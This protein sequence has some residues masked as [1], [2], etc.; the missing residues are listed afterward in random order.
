MY[1]ENSSVK[2]TEECRRGRKK[3]KK[4]RTNIVGHRNSESY[5]IDLYVDTVRHNNK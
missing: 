5:Y 3:E 4:L 1:T 2:S